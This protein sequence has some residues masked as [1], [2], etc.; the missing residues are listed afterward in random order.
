MLHTCSVVLAFLMHTK[1]GKAMQ[2]S[3][4]LPQRDR[5]QRL[6]RAKH[7]IPIGSKQG[8]GRQRDE[9]LEVSISLCCLPFSL[10]AAKTALNPAFISTASLLSAMSL[11]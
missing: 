5:E 10:N 3:H 7:D 11:L 4:M 1:D 9:D 8:R 2:L 6:A